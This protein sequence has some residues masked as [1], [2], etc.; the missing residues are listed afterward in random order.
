MQLDALA[1]QSEF[2]LRA[3]QQTVYATRCIAG[4]SLEVCAMIGERYLPESEAPET[5]GYAPSGKDSATP[6]E[7]DQPPPPPAPAKPTHAPRPNQPQR[8]R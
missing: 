3:D 7:S 4:S 2:M 1:G 8:P 5:R 6:G